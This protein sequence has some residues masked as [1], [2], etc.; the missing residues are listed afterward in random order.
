MEAHDTSTPS[1]GVP[2]LALPLGMPGGAGCALCGVMKKGPFGRG[3]VWFVVQ[4]V[5]YGVLCCDAL[6]FFTVCLL[7]LHDGKIV[8]EFS[9]EGLQAVVKCRPEARQKDALHV[10]R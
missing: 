10:R 9:R 6:F 5:V 4:Q 7:F 8:R 3:G 2:M 1:A